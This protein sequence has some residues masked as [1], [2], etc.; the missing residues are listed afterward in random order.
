[1]RYKTTKAELV[2][3]SRN[4]HIPWKSMKEVEEVEREF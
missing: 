1:M 3:V 2:K 4:L